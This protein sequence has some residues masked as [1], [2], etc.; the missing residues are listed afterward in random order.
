MAL[1]CNICALDHV[2]AA[3]APQL[4][5]ALL[6]AV[7]GGLEAKEHAVAETAALAL[8]QMIECAPLR[9]VVRQIDVPALFVELLGRERSPLFSL[10]CSARVRARAL[11]ALLA[12]RREL[13]EP[14]AACSAQ[15]E[16]ALQPFLQGG[17]AVVEARA[18]E[19][20]K[21]GGGDG[22]K[23]RGKAKATKRAASEMEAGANGATGEAA[24]AMAADRRAVAVPIG[25][26][27]V[28]QQPQQQWARPPAQPSAED[29]AAPFSS[30]L[31]MPHDAA[32]AWE[33]VSDPMLLGAMMPAH[34]AY[35]LA[36]RS[37]ELE[38]GMG[39]VGMGDV[40]DDDAAVLIMRGDG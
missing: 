10:H 31:R 3:A 4:S 2:V 24:A 34:G 36:P 5:A 28:Q 8:F 29:D 12:A 40:D 23:G 26:A 32:G 21:G 39:E 15:Q 17:A 35:D 1:L 18:R 11:R 14:F 37:L 19:L 13:P 27:A 25:A 6:R 38:L 22:S 9:P 16:S 33:A 7:L 30:A 20:R